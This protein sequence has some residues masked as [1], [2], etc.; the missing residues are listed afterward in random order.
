[1]KVLNLLPVF[2]LLGDACAGKIYVVNEQYDL[3]LH[4]FVRYCC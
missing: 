2:H 3:P 1:M 4:A